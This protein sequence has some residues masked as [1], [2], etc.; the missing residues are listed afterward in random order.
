MPI[1][2]KIE[3]RDFYKNLPSIDHE[4]GDIWRGLPTFGILKK[5]STSAVVITP[6]CDLSQKKTETIN[7]LPIIP[8]KEY[9]YTKAFYPE[10]WKEISPALGN[11]GFS[12]ISP[13]NKFSNPL[14]DEILEAAKSIEKTAKQKTLYQKLKNYHKYIT[15]TENPTKAPA[16]EI[17][18]IITEKKYNELLK[19]I[20]TNALKPDIH[21]FPADGL[22]LEYSAVPEHSVALFR[23]S[24]SIPLEVLDSAQ[25]SQ[26]SLW[27]QDRESLSTHFPVAK[28]FTNWPINLSTL[29]DDFL[30]DLL[31]RYLGM[32]IR[33]GS[34]DF[35]DKSIESFIDEIRRS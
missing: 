26:E 14:A 19:K 33:L 5:E 9:V 18:D 16:P 32:F 27:N 28:H 20:V 34:R 8:I 10:I 4:T 6:A 11:I 22:A 35:T 1:V 12:S 3:P 21:F 24:F 7:F 25:N 15:H 13:P 23:Y 30:S 31:S 2:Q 17:K 29:K